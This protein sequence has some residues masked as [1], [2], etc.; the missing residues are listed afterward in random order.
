[1]ENEAVENTLTA[2]QW[3]GRSAG[4]F[5]F[6]KRLCDASWL[7]FPWDRSDCDAAKLFGAKLINPVKDGGKTKHLFDLLEQV[8]RCRF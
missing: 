1:M 6:G 7:S 4:Y 3:F 2:E 5:E 8:F